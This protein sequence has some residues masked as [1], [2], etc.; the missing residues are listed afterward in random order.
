MA[1]AFDYLWRIVSDV[2][3]LAVV[4]YI[5]S[6]LHERPETVIVP[7]LGLIYVRV[8]ILQ[9]FTLGM[10]RVF[11]SSLDEVNER[12]KWFADA[13]YMRDH[14]EAA[15][16]RKLTS[17][18][19]TSIVDFIYLGLVSLACLWKLYLALPPAF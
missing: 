10:S 17:F 12:L 18:D 2:V 8:R 7:I 14:D 13:S 11:F 16:V 6:R 19:G 4:L 15:K 3:Y 1:T 9:V 5:L